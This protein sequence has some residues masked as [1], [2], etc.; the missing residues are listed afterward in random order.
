MYVKVTH[1][2][3]MGG[4]FLKELPGDEIYSGT[5][6]LP[7]ESSKQDGDLLG[8][9]DLG[10]LLWEELD[11]QGPFWHTLHILEINLDQYVH[12][13]PDDGREWLIVKYVWWHTDGISAVATTRNI[14]ILGDNG[15][16]IDRVR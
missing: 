11:F 1:G 12:T 6:I 2:K 13:D 4:D 8:G 16:T 10:S 7:W 5:A 14:F 3:N 15:K 9:N